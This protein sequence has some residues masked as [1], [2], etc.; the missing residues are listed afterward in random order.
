MVGN[1]VEME[2]QGDRNM[3]SVIPNCGLA[4]AM[5]QQAEIRRC[6]VLGCI[7]DDD[8]GRKLSESRGQDLYGT[9]YLSLLM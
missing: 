7:S 3:A 8:V 1:I 6:I 2:A 5:P 4:G 9:S